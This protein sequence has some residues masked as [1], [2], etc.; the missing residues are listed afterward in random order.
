MRAKLSDEMRLVAIP[1]LEGEAS[2]PDAR[3]PINQ[4]KSCAKPRQPTEHV[5]R[6][7]DIRPEHLLDAPTSESQPIRHVPGLARQ[8]AR[9]F[10]H[11]ATDERMGRSRTGLQSSSEDPLRLGQA[12]FGSSGREQSF[13]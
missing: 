6:H 10:D 9:Q 11:R 13:L 3:R 8:I 7:A 2:P 5:G 1:A 4:T 12:R